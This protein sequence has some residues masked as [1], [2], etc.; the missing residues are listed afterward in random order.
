MSVALWV[1]PVFAAGLAFT[2]WYVHG[3]YT[4]TVNALVALE[5][6]CETAFAD[7]DFQLKRRHNIIPGLASVEN[8]VADRERDLITRIRETEARALNA[9]ATAMR[10]R[11][12]GNLTAQVADLLAATDRDPHL[13]A[14]PEFAE[15]RRQLV[16]CENRIL[17][18]RRFYYRAMEEFNA[19]TQQF[20]GCYLAERMCRMSGHPSSL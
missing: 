16:D 15:L 20:P 4:N 13:K 17:E 2:A 18:G 3:V 7:M 12:E 8:D 19:A 9:V 10:M 5:R 14:I 6:R 11:A 1:L